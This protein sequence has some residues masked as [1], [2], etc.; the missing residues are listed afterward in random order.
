[1][2]HVIIQND[3]RG[4]QTGLRGT[5]MGPAQPN[6]N[7]PSSLFHPAVPQGWCCLFG[8][9]QEMAVGDAGETTLS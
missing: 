6:V 5:T 1:M 3:L 8:I 7:R 4:M 2:H 9:D